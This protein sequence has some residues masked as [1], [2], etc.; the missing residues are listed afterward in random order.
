MVETS[1]QG[2]D[3]TNVKEFVSRDP[4]IKYLGYEPAFTKQ[5]EE[6]ARLSI[7]TQ[8][9]TWYHKF[10]TSKN[11]KEF[12]IQYLTLT[13]RENDAKTIR[14]VDE[15][16]L[17]IT[18]CWLSRMVLRG[19]KLTEQEEHKLQTYITYI[20]ST[21]TTTVET[22]V[23]PSQGNRPN[24]QEL[25]RNKAIEAAGELEGMFDKYIADGAKAS[26]DYKPMDELS[27]K[28]VM[29]QHISLFT[30][31]WQTKKDEFE[32]VLEGKDVQL[33][34]GYQR[35]SKTQLKNIV[36]F[37]DSCIAD[38]NSYVSMKKANKA[39][40]KRK[41]VPVEKQVRK[42]KYLKEF[43]DASLNLNL[44]GVSPTKLLDAS[45]AWV[46]DTAKR[47]LHHYVADQ[48][49]K[50]FSVKGNTL[51]GFDTK[52]SEVKTLRKPDKQIKEVMGSKPAARKFFK[53]IRA[54][55]VTPKGR[56]NKDM[57]ILKAF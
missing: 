15:R 47:K 7:M 3:F 24:V 54:V 55:S 39:P 11:A 14:K 16:D 17:N 18:M 21:V 45:E 40:R 1:K 29:P 9:F 44:V 4:D 49:N 36:K 27:K 38:F 10:C 20:L 26:F 56:F 33:V 13:K 28:N 23:Q 22:E 12:F 32:E 5:P 25:M 35:F 57:I 48:Y 43:K 37:I 2:F 19:L 31:A 6:G 30:D 8:A 51:L 34:E 46:Y 52:E 41:P 50:T 42:L 53:E